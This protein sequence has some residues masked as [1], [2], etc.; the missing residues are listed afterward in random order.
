MWKITLLRL[1]MP[2]SDFEG[3][4]FVRRKAVPA[5]EYLFA[6]VVVIGDSQIRIVEPISIRIIT[7]PTVSSLGSPGSNAIDELEALMRSWRH[8]GFVEYRESEKN[9]NEAD[10]RE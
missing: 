3:I 1:P 2:I 9:G 5:F 10:K 6:G 8:G 7:R 4:G